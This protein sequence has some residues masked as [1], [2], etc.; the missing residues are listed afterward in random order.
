MLKKK[1]FKAISLVCAFVI[2]FTATQIGA[3]A[4]SELSIVADNVV[5]TGQSIQ[6]EA[7]SSGGSVWAGEWSSNDSKV[8]SCSK[9]G[10]I[11]GLKEGYARITVK[12]GGASASKTIYCVEKPDKTFST[13]IDQG[14]AFTSSVPGHFPIQTIL[15]NFSPFI[16]PVDLKVKGMYDSFLYIEY[17]AWGKSYKGFIS[18]NRVYDSAT[19]TVFSL[20]AYD[21]NIYAGKSKGL[22]TPYNGTVTWKVSD[23]DIISYDSSTGMVYAKKPGIATVSAT[24][25]GK[26]LT[27]TVHSI[28]QWPSEWT[29][30]AKTATYVYKAE[31]TGYT[32]SATSLA[33]GAKFTVKGDLGNSDGYAYGSTSS[34]VWGYVPIKDISTKNTISFYNNLNWRYP[35]QNTSYNYIRSPYGPRSSF[36]DMHRGFDI[37]TEPGHSSISEQPIVSAFDGVVKKVGSDL[38]KKDGC[39]HYACIISNV[40]DPVT[41]KAIIAIYMHMSKEVNLKKGQSI[42]RGDFI[43]NVGS[44]GNST[45]PHLHFEVNNWEAAVGDSGRSDFT[46]TINPIYFYVDIAKNGGFVFNNDCDAVIDGYGFY[47]Y[48]KDE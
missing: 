7:K 41:G 6:L 4:A 5:L 17:T 32:K 18:K 24:A 36:N 23:S 13:T 2:C 26:T 34:G 43:G 1:L 35:L 48:K 16:K 15:F 44:T 8:I 12:Y 21:L 47:F 31:G 39:G 14:I 28:Y 46:Y 25:N 30:K 11:K 37:S 40:T 29:G 19:G 22:T 20:T 33:S 45:G 3:Q 42:K 9:S 10:V 38:N 27:C